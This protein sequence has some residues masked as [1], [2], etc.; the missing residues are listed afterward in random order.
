EVLCSVLETSERDTEAALWEALQHELIVRSER[1]YRFGHD[2]VQE[3][4]YSLIPEGMRAG[5]HLRIGRLLYA[6]TPPEKL[7]E[8]VF[9]IV[10][11]LNRGAHLIDSRA[12]REQAAQLNLTA[13]TRAKAS[14]AYTAALG[15]LASGRA[16]LAQETW[17]SN[18][19]LVFA[20][21]CLIA[22]CELL[23]A[24]MA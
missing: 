9:E 23:T 6:H 1:S 17:D 22:E 16:L 14:T 10:S 2:R 18:H 20:I 12:E 11:Q 15:Y 7:E 5:S 3:A 13:A 19:G 21:E 24:E 8:A 4:A